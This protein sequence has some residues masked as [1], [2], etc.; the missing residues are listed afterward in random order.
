MTS[1]ERYLSGL[2][3]KLVAPL[4]RRI[5]ITVQRVVLS[6][7][8]DATKAQ[9]VQ[10]Q[11]LA[12][13]VREQVERIQEYGFTSV[14]EKGAEGVAVAVGAG[15]HQVVVATDDRRYR[16]KNLSPGDVA[17]YRL[18]EG[19]LV[20][21]KAGQMVELGPSP[22]QFVALAN[23][24]LT[25]LNKLATDLNTLKTVFSSGW[26][27]SPGDGGA[28]LKTAAGTWAGQTLTMSSVAATKVKAK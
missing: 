21:L 20:H 18:A 22:T 23:L 24:V 4:K 25:E 5:A 3:G 14:P 26:A 9:I 2:V 27:V 8:D 10:I 15:G 28:A 17:L 11:G 19:I 12:D 13:S 7:I 6:A 16:P 1:D